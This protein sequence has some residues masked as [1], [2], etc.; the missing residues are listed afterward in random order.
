MFRVHADHPHH[1]FAV[2]NFALVAHLLDRST[3]F[4]LEQL[5]NLPA[6]SLTYTGKLFFLYSDRRVKVP[7]TP[8]RQEESE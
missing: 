8:D 7:L 1:T 5:S 2:D 6:R 4:H 3:H